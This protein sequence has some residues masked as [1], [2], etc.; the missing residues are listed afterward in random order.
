MIRK[1][2]ASLCIYREI[3]SSFNANRDNRVKE[4]NNELHDI[5]GK[6]CYDSESEVEDSHRFTKITQFLALK[7]A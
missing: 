1:G 7:K 5:V 3:H 2:G 6:I 4:L